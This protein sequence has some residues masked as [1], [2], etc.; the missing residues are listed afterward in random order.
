MAI[1][2]EILQAS[3]LSDAALQ[4]LMLLTEQSGFEARAVG[5]CVRDTLL[6]LDGPVDVD[7]ATTMPAEDMM[8][9]LRDHDFK[10]VPTGLAHGTITAMTRDAD[11]R[12]FEI[13]TLRRDVATDGR[14]AVTA[15]T[16]DWLED[17]RRRDF[18]INAL[19]VAADG[20]IYDPLAEAGQGSGREDVA[21][22]RVRFIGQAEAR[23]TEDFLRILRFFRFHFRLAPHQPPDEA[24]FAACR[25]LASGIKHLSPERI[26]DEIRKIAQLDSF[27][28][29]LR[30]MEA[31]GLWS[32]IF[33]SPSPSQEM[34]QALER[35][36]EMTEEPL[37]RLGM[38]FARPQHIQAARLRFSNA[39]KDRLEA[40][41]DPSIAAALPDETA[42]Q[43]LYFKAAYWHGVAACKDHLLLRAARN[44]RRP[45]HDLIEALAAW[46]KPICPVRGED[47]MA[48]GLA[49]GPDLGSALRR[50]ERAWVDSN[51]TLTRADLLQRLA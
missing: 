22:R 27:A 8:Q 9:L 16:D 14:H 20:R 36:S 4:R 5:G 39:D 49:A 13:T 43:D 41:L 15:Y 38:L 50:L 25:A 29:C 1:A 2:P 47:L 45:P 51:F 34:F 3:W 28:S 30:S 46:Q 32:A 40:M 18:T 24:A 44:R 37:V 35:L 10:V 33:A 12:H 23:I 26:T 17:A 42:A 6:G 19:Y 31:A 11:P 48:L 7:V 21:Q